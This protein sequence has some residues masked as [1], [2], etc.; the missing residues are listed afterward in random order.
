[1]K[2]EVLNLTC[3][4]QNKKGRVIHGSGLHG[5]HSSSFVSPEEKVRVLEWSALRVVNAMT[6]TIKLCVVKPEEFFVV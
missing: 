5:S 2:I 1:M 6:A 3:F 4:P